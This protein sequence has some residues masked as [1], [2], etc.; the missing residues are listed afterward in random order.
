MAELDLTPLPPKK[1]SAPGIAECPI[2]FECKVVHKNDVLPPALAGDITREYYAEGDFHRVY[3][4]RIV[5][6]SVDRGLL[7]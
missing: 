6:V 7:A 2:V 4:G 1:I 5:R 3:Y